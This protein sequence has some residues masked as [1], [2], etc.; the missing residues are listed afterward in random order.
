MA[1]YIKAKELG[2]YILPVL[3]KCDMDSARPEEV[4]EEI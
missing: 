3:N 4:I 2:L 1:N